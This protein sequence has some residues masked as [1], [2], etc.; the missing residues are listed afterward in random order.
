MNLTCISI[1]CHNRFQPDRSSTISTIY[2]VHLG[3][4]TA[5]HRR[6]FPNFAVIWLCLLQ[7]LRPLSPHDPI[8]TKHQAFAP[9]SPILFVSKYSSVRLEFC[10]NAS[11][12][13]WQETNDLITLKNDL[14][15]LYNASIQSRE[16]MV[17]M[18][19]ETSDWQTR[20][21]VGAVNNA[22]SSVWGCS[23]DL[24]EGRVN[25]SWSA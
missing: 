12:T 18:I 14:L 7:F 25:E 1:I 2:L 20:C 9:S 15:R 8:L 23:F 5:L 24:R 16:N 6:H 10:C 22:Q 17:P 19:C 4:N 11:A 13:A 3:I 21:W